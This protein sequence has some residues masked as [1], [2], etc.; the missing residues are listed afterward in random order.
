[1]PGAIPHEKLME[2]YKGGKV[3]L[4]VLPSIVTP[5]GEHEGIPVALMEAMA[6]GIPVISTN[7]GG[8][9][10]LLSAGAGTIVEGK[11]PEQLVKAIGSLLED[12]DLRRKIGVAGYQRVKEEFNTAANVAG[13]I[14]AMKEKD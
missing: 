10:E 13:L 7:T 8:I 6:Y 5:Q 1:M 2:M 12:A 11:T 4:V 14:A 9:P 3:D